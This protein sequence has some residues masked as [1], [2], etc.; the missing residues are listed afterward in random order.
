MQNMN[1]HHDYSLE[2]AKAIA[3]FFLHK[4]YWEEEEKKKKNKK[5]AAAS[6]VICVQRT[7]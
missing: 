4:D 3:A 5:P 7:R 2:R 6:A 1:C